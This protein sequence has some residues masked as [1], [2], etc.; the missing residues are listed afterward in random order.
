[1]EILR[2]NSTLVASINDDNY[3]RR[4]KN[5]EMKLKK[6]FPWQRGLEEIGL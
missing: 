3:L 5:G 1:M 4:G 6:C 2:A